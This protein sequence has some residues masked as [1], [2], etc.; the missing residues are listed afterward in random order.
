MRALVRRG[1][2][3]AAV[4]LSV[5]LGGCDSG[6]FGPPDTRPYAPAER[7]AGTWRWVSSFDVRTQVAHTPAT[8][9]HGATLQFTAESAR[10]GTFT[11][12]R[13]GSLPVTGRFEI[14]SEHAPGNDFV[15]LQPGID[16][17]ARN[18]WVS[19][20]SD[21]LYLGGVMELGYNSRYARV[22]P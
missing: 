13:A 14:G 5:G 12:T 6:P 19:A 10:T 7:L 2:F 11:Y 1:T 21:S 20:G 18:A 15:V 17:L 8:T 16:Y 3:V 22:T 9:G 4:G